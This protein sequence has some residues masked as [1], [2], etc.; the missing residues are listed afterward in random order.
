MRNVG[1]FQVGQMTYVFADVTTGLV[2]SA[3]HLLARRTQARVTLV[4][5]T[6]LVVT[7]GRNPAQLIATEALL[8]DAAGPGGDGGL[9]PAVQLLGEVARV[10]GAV[11]ADRLALV[12]A[13]LQRL[14]AR[15]LARRAC[16]IA[17]LTVACM[18]VAISLPFAL[19]FTNVLFGARHFV[20]V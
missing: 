18:Q 1:F 5:L 10:A 12:F 20:G 6:L 11:V 15:L 4:R 8:V 9:A 17:T 14:A 3:T 7:V 2:F 19:R 16:A 13:A